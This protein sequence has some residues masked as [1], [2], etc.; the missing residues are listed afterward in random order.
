MIAADEPEAG[1]R[2]IHQRLTQ[3]LPAL[4]P[5]VVTVDVAPTGESC[6]ALLHEVVGALVERPDP[7]RIW[8][9][10]VAM[11]ATF[12]SDDDVQAA[13]RQLEL[14]SVSECCIWLLEWAYRTVQAHRSGAYELKLVQDGVVVDV[15]FTA[16]HDLQTGIQRVVRRLVPRW[17]RDHAIELAVWAY[18]DGA[19]R[20]LDDEE[21]ERVLRWTRPIRRDPKVCGNAV[22]A[23]VTVPWRSTL[24]LPEVP[25]RDQCVRLASLAQHSGNRVALV[26]YDCIPVLSA[27][28]MPEVEPNRFVRYLGLVKH[29]DVLAG[30][31][32]SAAQEFRGFV[33][34]LPTQGLVGPRVVSCPLA[35]DASATQSGPVQGTGVPEILVV[36]SHEPRK[37]HGAVLHAAEVLWR[38]G[39][40]FRLR[41]IGAG[42]WTT[43][44]FDRRLEMLLAAGRPVALERGMDDEHLWAAYRQARFTV[45]P[46]L[47]EGYGLPVVE[48]LNFGTPVIATGYGS[49]AELADDGGV[50]LVDPH[51]DAELLSAM[52]SLLTDDT[53]LLRLREEALARPVRT[54]DDYAAE[55]WQH[56]M[57]AA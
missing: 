33:E 24:V 3:A 18:G 39:L 4:L 46:S 43:T 45:F 53:R 16:K 36:G 5:D 34:A 22:V 14:A 13:R 52:R 6:G 28:L 37:N 17:H 55:L 29:A 49:I 40:S 47:H 11:S 41:F 48:S 26:A 51:S 27:D 23:V 9:L 20:V 7:E 38:E 50:V 42:G 15:D 57:T 44:D 56:L 54:W 32:A 21:Q 19:L 1:L 2:A 31:S 12:P 30:I 35:T 10:L 8:L 25:G